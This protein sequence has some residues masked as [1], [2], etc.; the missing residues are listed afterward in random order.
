M[1]GRRVIQLESVKR[2]DGCAWSRGV[3]SIISWCKCF[4]IVGYKI[5][6]VIGFIGLCSRNLQAA[7]RG[8]YH[9][10]LCVCTL[11]EACVSCVLCA[12]EF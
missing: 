5:I 9:C 3:V 7:K 8:Q 2:D 1:N 12:Q 4:M 11:R 6:F 10:A